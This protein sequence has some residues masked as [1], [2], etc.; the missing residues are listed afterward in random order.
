MLIRFT[1]GYLQKSFTFNLGWVVTFEGKE[2]VQRSCSVICYHHSPFY[3]K[4]LFVGVLVAFRRLERD[5]ERDKRKREGYLLSLP[6]ST[7]F[8]IY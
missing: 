6:L 5:I 8:Y 4:Q 2:H 7:S 3:L 1:P